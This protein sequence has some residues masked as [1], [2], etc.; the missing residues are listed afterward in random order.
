MNKYSIGTKSFKMKSLTDHLIA[1][2][3]HLSYKDYWEECHKNNK[4]TGYSSGSIDND[5]AYIW[6]CNGYHYVAAYDCIARAVLDIHGE[7]IRCAYAYAN[8]RYAKRDDE[9]FYPNEDH[10]RIVRAFREYDSHENLMKVLDIAIRYSK[11]YA[12]T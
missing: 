9:K 3:D 12:F 6:S 4:V 2:K 7:E 1:I 10:L 11:L 8:Y 5:L